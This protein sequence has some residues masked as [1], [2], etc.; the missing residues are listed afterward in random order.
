MTPFQ[1]GEI[2]LLVLQVVLQLVLQHKVVRVLHRL[3][4]LR[5]ILMN[6]FDPKLFALQFAV[7]SQLTIYLSLHTSLARFSSS[8][9]LH[10]SLS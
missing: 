10:P 4:A 5:S 2:C 8:L 9:R 6:I 7:I 1:V 3:L